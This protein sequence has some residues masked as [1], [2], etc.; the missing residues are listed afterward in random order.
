LKNATANCASTNRD[1]LAQFICM[2][3]LGLHL[4]VLVV[5]YVKLL[6]LGCAIHNPMLTFIPLL[7]IFHS[8]A[9]ERSLIASVFRIEECPVSSQQRKTIVIMARMAVE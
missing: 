2:W 9:W 5:V 6:A 1:V 4:C 3:G 7:R 8:G